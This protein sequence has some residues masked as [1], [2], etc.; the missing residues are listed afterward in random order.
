MSRR[1]RKP[2]PT[3]VPSSGSARRPSRGL[4]IAAT[5]VI[6]TVLIG[7]A[8]SRLGWPL[9]NRNEVQTTPELH[10]PQQAIASADAYQKG[11]ALLNTHRSEEAI[12]YLRRAIAT[13]ESPDWHMHLDLSS[14]L[15]NATF[16]IELWKGIPRA[17]IHPSVTRIAYVREMLAEASK[18]DALCRTAEEHAEVQHSLALS[19]QAWGFFWE[20]YLAHRE[21][22]Q[23]APHNPT[24]LRDGQ[25][26]E[27]M[28][29]DPEQ[30]LA[31]MSR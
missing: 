30:P 8:I 29:R 17:R 3:A 27:A 31:P 7:I 24:Y 15:Y 20:A 5:L 6:L 14:A 2:A 1:K 19:W 16:E 28:M 13:A 9:R 21:A 12:P 22:I 26:L 11:R 23:A 10:D 18:A 25:G 4:A